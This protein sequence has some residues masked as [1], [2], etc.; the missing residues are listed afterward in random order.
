[1]NLLY[2]YQAVILFVSG[3]YV[4]SQNHTV[5]TKYGE[6]IGKEII[7]SL[8]LPFT[9]V[10]GYLG[11]PFAKPPVED[12]RWKAPQPAESWEGVLE[13]KKFGAR[14]VQP[15]LWHDMLFR[16]ENDSEDCLFLNVWSP[17]KKGESGLP[18]LVYFYG[19]GFFGG[20]GC[21]K[22]YDGA[23]MAQKGIVT[24][25]VNYRLNIFGFLPDSYWLKK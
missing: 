21:E 24:L 1:M 19:G 5:N 17:A 7:V 10:H 25:T 18:V 14:P 8:D 15:F 23:S 22:R 20:A 13:T 6:I 4:N 9:K 12:L 11:I 2:N 3:I 16:S